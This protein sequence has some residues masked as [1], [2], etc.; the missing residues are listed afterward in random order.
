[1]LRNLLLLFAFL[2]CHLS[3]SSAQTIHV[4][5]PESVKK[6]DDLLKIS[7]PSG[8]YQNKK[9]YIE[10]AIYISSRL[11]STGTSNIFSIV[12]NVPDEVF[13]TQYSAKDTGYTVY[14]NSSNRLPDGV[15]QVQYR[16]SSIAPKEI[17]V[18][19]ME[20]VKI[21]NDIVVKDNSK[22]EAVKAA[23]KAEKAK[24]ESKPKTEKTNTAATK[25]KKAE[26]KPAV[27]TVKDTSTKAEEAG[28][29]KF[30][31]YLDGY[32]GYYT[33]EVGISNYQ[34]F[35]TVSPRSNHIGLNAAM[36]SA[37]YDG[38]KYRGIL[39]LHYGDI[40]RSA[41]SP[42]FNPLLEAHAGVYLGKKIWLDAG[43]FRTHFGTESLF[44][45][46]NLASSISINTF[47]EPYY[48]A[49]FRLNYNP[50]DK[51]AL[52]L[53]L[54]NGYN[55]FEDNNKKKSIGMLITYALSDKGNIGYSNYIGDDMPDSITGSHVRISQNLFWNYTVRKLKI[56]V[57]A[58]FCLQENSNINKA[59]MGSMA[60]GI[61]TFKYQASKKI[62]CYERTEV[63][64]DPNGIMSGIF[65]DDIGNLTGFKLFGETLGIE[66]KHADNTYLRLEARELI[67]DKNQKIF[68]WDNTIRNYRTEVTLSLGVS[69]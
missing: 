49:G 56:Q 22:K 61:L 46:E 39:S 9:Y 18:S 31:A 16:I 45:K 5:M 3:E 68:I 30:S 32:F 29:I 8:D 11:I 43:F 62:A 69:F 7:F 24:P 38:A 57:G 63:F 14:S 42:T 50:N 36:I 25:P 66:Y 34:K 52:N 65:K 53:Y 10:M 58:D 60:S 26:N 37:Q 47:Y 23:P 35:P 64:H 59:G 33:D 51:L 1:M 4:R 55:L 48:E 27:E 28:G 17:I 13:F 19:Q 2:L 41:W 40:A 12:N 20:T 67:M 21:G 54:L 15:Y 6:A 44:P